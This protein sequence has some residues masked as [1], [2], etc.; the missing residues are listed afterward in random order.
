MRPQECLSI[1]SLSAI[2]NN[3][4]DQDDDVICYEM[5][6]WIE[7]YEVGNVGRNTFDRKLN[8]GLKS[9]RSQGI[10]HIRA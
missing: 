9:F 3:Q 2:W 5:I 8:K 6:V 1:F 10:V 7:V 4:R